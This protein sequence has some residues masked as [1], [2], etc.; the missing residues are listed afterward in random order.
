MLYALS[1]INLNFQ[2]VI[3][4]LIIILTIVIMIVPRIYIHDTPS[5]YNVFLIALLI[6]N[7]TI[8]ALTASECK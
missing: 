3:S 8:S 2:L 4:V 6:I 7:A 1:G 5:T